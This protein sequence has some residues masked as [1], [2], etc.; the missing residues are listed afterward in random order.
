MSL[1]I[2]GTEPG[3]RL[4][5]FL[6]SKID[7]SRSQIQNL[8]AQGKVVVNGTR[9]KKNYI[10]QGGEEIKVEFPQIPKLK[11][12][13]INFDIIY[14]DKNLALINKPAGLT[15][16]PGSGQIEGTLVSGLLALG[17]PLSN[18]EGE[19]R[20]GIVHRLDKGTSGLLI[21]AKDN[22]THKFLKE[23]M[24]QKRIHRSYLALVEGVPKWENNEV[25]GFIQRNPRRP[26]SFRMGDQGR[27]SRTSFRL[28]ED[29]GDYS[30]IECVLDTGRTHQ[31]RVHLKSIHFPIVGDGVYGSKKR[32]KKYKHQML[33][34]KK[35]EFTHPKGQKM[36]FTAPLPDEF[37]LLL[38][39]VRK[40]RSY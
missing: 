26:T 25:E 3:I 27:F 24:M 18:L 40:S 35:L 13:S 15:M 10:I 11:A 36:S 1:K 22:D 12:E 14:E 2:T 39:K 9:V 16:H 23:E 20:P 32:S 17:W 8:I 38:D 31:I 37:A 19:E 6:S 29:L 5:L 30:L 33:H 28:I 4:D 7:H 34:A 21:I